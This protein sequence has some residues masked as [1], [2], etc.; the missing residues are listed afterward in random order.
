M[1]RRAAAYKAYYEHMPLRRAS[2]PLGPNMQLYRRLTFGNLAE[3]SVLDT[4]Q[5]RTDQPCGDGNQPPRP[6]SLDAGATMLGAVQE[7]WLFQGLDRSKARWNVVAQQVMMA[8]VDR[9]PA[10]TRCSAWISGAAMSK[11]ESMC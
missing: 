3:F 1:A 5:Y 4:R 9:R 11:A 6:A 8:Q 2:L 7:R 10:P